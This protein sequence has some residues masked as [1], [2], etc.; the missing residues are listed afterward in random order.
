[1]TEQIACKK[2]RAFVAD[3]ARLIS[4]DATPN[5]DAFRSFVRSS[6]PHVAASLESVLPALR[7]QVQIA[8]RWLITHDLL[9]IA[10]LT[11]VEDAY[12]E[13]L[14]WAL[15]PE[16][17]FESALA[18]QRSWIK[19]LGLAEVLA[20]RFAA[21]P[22]TQ[23]VTD[24]GRPDL[25]LHYDDGV[26][27][28]EAKTGTVEHEA[29]SGLSQTVAYEPAIR[30]RLHLS[31]SIPVHIVF[32]TTDGASAA[33]P[34]AIKSTFLRSMLAIVEAIEPFDLPSDFRA[35]H[36]MLFS[37]FATRAAPWGID[38]KTLIERVFRWT[39]ESDW[40]ERNSIERRI[41]DLIL[42]LDA[43]MEEY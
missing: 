41:A 14:A 18:R 39:D 10:G 9:A 34:K 1:V 31:S 20:V 37:H 26:I 8:H 15:S 12:T 32:L 3:S 21:T 4:R 27:V 35:A 38:A 30:N 22:S 19:S 29:P 24:D 6:I 7:S 2:F 17:H 36:Q 33:N 11:Y 23:V 16:T 25:V 13:L 40:S 42:T 43:L 28:V 5:V